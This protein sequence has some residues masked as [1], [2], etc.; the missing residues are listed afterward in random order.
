MN[1]EGLVNPR[2]LNRGNRRNLN[3]KLCKYIHDQDNYSFLKF[4]CLAAHLSFAEELKSLM[5]IGLQIIYFKST[6]WNI[7][8]VWFYITPLRKSADCSNY[9]EVNWFEMVV[10]RRPGLIK[11]KIC[12]LPK[13][14][15]TKLI[16]TMKK[17]YFLKKT[18]HT[19]WLV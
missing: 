19:S 14:Y 15:L 13:T 12:I 6:I 17:I 10:W 4:V 11:K 1:S 5:A 16:L 18:A 7:R 2:V 3:P 8:F 9:T